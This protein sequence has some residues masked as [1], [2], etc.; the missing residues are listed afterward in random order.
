MGKKIKEYLAVIIRGLLEIIYPKEERCIVCGEEDIDGLCNK[1]KYNITY[2]EG[3]ELSIGFYKGTLK[4]LIL[5]FKFKKRFDAGE[6]LVKLIEDKFI[7]LVGKDYIVTYIPI[8]KKSLEVRGFNQCEYLAR[9][10]GIRNG[11]EVLNLL[12][13]VKETKAQKTL[14]KEE[15]FNNIKGAFRVINEK[16]VKGRKVLIIDDVVTTGATLMEAEKILKESGALK[17]KILTLAKSHI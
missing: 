16:D 6:E 3:S 1:C 15:R 4:E 5:L 9:E 8:E 14:K 11:Y 13:K 2:S 12:E 17:I 7:S 10:L